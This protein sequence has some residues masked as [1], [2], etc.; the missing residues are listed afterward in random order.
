M[1]SSGTQHTPVTRGINKR[2]R[3]LSH[4]FPP[5]PADSLTERIHKVRQDELYHH[6]FFKF[7]FVCFVVF[8]A[9]LLLLQP[10]LNE[11]IH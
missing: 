4:V 7:V 11:V 1:L 6:K 8:A 10:E 2:N 5:A 3:I 9:S